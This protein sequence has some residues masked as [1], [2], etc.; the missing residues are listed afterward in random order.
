MP[1]VDRTEWVRLSRIERD[2]NSALPEFWEGKPVVEASLD[3][4]LRVWSK[5]S[6]GAW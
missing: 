4:V 3:D 6:E 5:G 2:K 1:D